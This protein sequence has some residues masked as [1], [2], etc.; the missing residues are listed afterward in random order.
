MA[1]VEADA[2]RIRQSVLRSEVL[3]SRHGYEAALEDDVSIDEIREALISGMILEDY[4]EDQR[5]A[6]CLMYGKTS[7]G[8]DLHVVVTKEVSPVLVIT[9]YEPKP[10]AWMTPEERGPK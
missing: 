9:V 2:D 3:L 1:D 8:R 5:G 10:P 6:S 7:S 4:P